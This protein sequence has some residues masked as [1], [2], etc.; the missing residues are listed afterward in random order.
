MSNSVLSVPTLISVKQL[1]EAIINH[2]AAFPVTNTSNRL[3]GLIPRS[4]LIILGK[5][6]AFYDKALITNKDNL[7]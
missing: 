3:V 2:H 7:Q 1:K 4:I 6:R 5:E